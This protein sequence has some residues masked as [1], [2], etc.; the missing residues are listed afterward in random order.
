V[1]TILP[2][3]EHYVQAVQEC[4]DRDEHASLIFYLF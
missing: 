2:V 3:F 1:A 4:D